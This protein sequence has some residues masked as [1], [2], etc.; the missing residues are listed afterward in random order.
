MEFMVNYYNIVGLSLSLS[1]SLNYLH[2][3]KRMVSLFGKYSTHGANIEKLLISI[4]SSGLK[5]WEFPMDNGI[6]HN[7]LKQDKLALYT[8][9]SEKF[10]RLLSVTFDWL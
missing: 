6:L 8:K 3:L 9:F 2:I 5:F 4:K 10:L 1:L 7:L